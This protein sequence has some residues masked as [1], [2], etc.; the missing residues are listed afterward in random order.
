MM[1][2]ALLLWPS[3]GPWRVHFSDSVAQRPAVFDDF[4]IV[5]DK[6]TTSAKTFVDADVQGV[7]DKI[8]KELHEIFFGKEKKK[9][10]PKERKSENQAHLFVL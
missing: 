4:D 9:A 7:P 8:A 3:R 5:D 10:F 1:L 2:W 6:S